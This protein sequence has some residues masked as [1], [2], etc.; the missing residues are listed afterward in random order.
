MRKRKTMQGDV[1][2]QNGRGRKVTN[3]FPALPLLVL[4]A[5]GSLKANAQTSVTTFH[6]DI[7]RTGQNLNETILTTSNVNASQFGKLFSQ[8]IDGQVYA[9]PLYL[10]N[11]TI[12]GQQ[13]NVV[14]VATEN[15]TVY[16]FD[17]DSNS[18]ANANPLWMAS[19]LTA[20]HGAA[21]GATAVPASMLSGDLTPV[22][23]I[24]GTPVIDPTTNTFYVVSKT[25][26]GGSA[27]QRL[28]ALDVTTGNEKFGG[29]VAITATAAGTGNGS[30][31]GQI[32]FDPHW[33]NQRPALLLLNGI[34]YIAF[35]AHGDNGPWHGWILG[36]NA[37]T[38][39]QTG[40]Y[41]ASPN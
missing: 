27:V 2:F 35:G 12:G 7:G 22:V 6:N 28:H 16:A 23:G 29:P 24:T 9:Q 40:A 20:A 8:P 36:Y 10:P 13:H 32:T 33:E 11:V 14:F 37:A 31:G 39:T 21:S 1:E 3:Q 30:S 5:A 26:E 41:N 4:A 15:D 19:M 38:L 18:G 17:A 34:V 25:L